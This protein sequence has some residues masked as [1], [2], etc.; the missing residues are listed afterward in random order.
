MRRLRATESRNVTY[1]GEGWPVFWERARGAN[2]ED[3]DGNVYVDLTGAFGVA[4]M[5]HGHPGVMAAV[6][7]QSELLV[8]GM[9]DVHP[10]AA[11]VDFLERLCAVAPWPW[12]PWRSSATWWTTASTSG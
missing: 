6:R 8:H 5:G 12:A 10:P 2:V 1:T 9:G 4:L 11:K 3:A 7:R